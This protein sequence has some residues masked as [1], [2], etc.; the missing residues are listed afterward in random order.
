MWSTPEQKKWHFIDSSKSTMFIIVLIF[1]L[2]LVAPIWPCPILARSRS[3]VSR[4][5]EALALPTITMQV[6]VVN[7]SISAYFLNTYIYKRM[8]LITR[9]YY[10]E[11]RV[12]FSMVHVTRLVLSIITRMDRSSCS[13]YLHFPRSA[14]K[15]IRN[16]L[17]IYVIL[18]ITLY[19]L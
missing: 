14:V 16:N 3:L 13:N 2:V 11:P 10:H 6:G 8:H 12:L 1:N 17:I 4:H 7:T 15:W 5:S 9:L 19:A 18:L